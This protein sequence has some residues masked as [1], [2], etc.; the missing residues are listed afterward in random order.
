MKKRIAAVLVTG[1]VL[2]SSMTVSARVING[3]IVHTHMLSHNYTGSTY[4]AQIRTESRVYM[5]LAD[6]TIITRPYVIYGIYQ[7]C[8]QRCGCGVSIKCPDKHLIRIVEG[9]AY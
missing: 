6:G 9:W 5:V 3:P 1:M 8:E 4:Q 2:L 7:N